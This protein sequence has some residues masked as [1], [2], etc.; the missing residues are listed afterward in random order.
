[1]SWDSK[2][3]HSAAVASQGG[4][5]SA[6]QDIVQEYSSR[7]LTKPSDTIPAL[8]GLAKK[9]HTLSNAIY[10]AGIWKENLL[11]DLAWKRALESVFDSPECYLAPTFSWA[12]LLCGVTYNA[13]R[14]SY[15][16]TRVYH[17][18]IE[19]VELTKAYEELFISNSGTIVLQGPVRLATL[20]SSNIKDPH[21]YQLRIGLRDFNSEIYYNYQSCGHGCEFSIDCEL[22][23][24]NLTRDRPEE[25]RL[26]PIRRMNAK[27]GDELPFE[28]VEVELLSLYT[29]LSEIG[30]EAYE[31]FLILGRDQDDPSLY[32]RIGMGTGK[33]CPSEV[34]R[35]V[36][37]SGAAFSWLS[38]IDV[39]QDDPRSGHVKKICIK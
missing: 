21:S 22:M 30:A 19:R 12:S 35:D 6:W 36:S 9:F 11:E 1:M 14:W 16:G 32:K 2:S 18:S 10:L 23:A 4:I 5:H 34:Q 3:F 8:A 13:A 7:S 28:N 15:G 17:S 31:N 24:H 29:I 27:M 33:L 25:S 26:T 37:V 20:S 38:D 39:D